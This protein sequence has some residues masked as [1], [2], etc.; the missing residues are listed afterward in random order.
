MNSFDL[1]KFYDL[2]MHNFTTDLPNC[3]DTINI[4]TTPPLMPKLVDHLQ[5]PFVHQKKAHILFFDMIEIRDCYFEI[6]NKFNFSVFNLS[7]LTMNW[8]N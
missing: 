4:F 3:S 1:T 2:P 7:N 6:F 5:N 8:Y